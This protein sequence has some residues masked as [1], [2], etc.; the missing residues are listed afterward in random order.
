MISHRTAP[1]GQIIS[2]P[3]RC[4]HGASRCRKRDHDHRRLRRVCRVPRGTPSISGMRMSLTIDRRA[5]GEARHALLP[6]LAWRTHV[7]L[8]VSSSTQRPRSTCS[9]SATRMDLLTG[10]PSTNASILG[11][12]G[13]DASSRGVAMT[14]EEEDEQR[15]HERCPRRHALGTAGQHRRRE[16]IAAPRA[17]RGDRSAARKST[18]AAVPALGAAGVQRIGRPS[19]S[20]G[21]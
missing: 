15:D 18:T 13:G 21:G 12:G 9:S 20:S 10:W 14:D 3:A 11:F 1:V 7:S 19:V 16:N 2:A 8:S 6:L 5:A 4:L 17:S